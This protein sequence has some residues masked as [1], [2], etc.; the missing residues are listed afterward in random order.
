MGKLF[1]SLEGGAHGDTLE[2]EHE[3][4]F[5][6]CST[7]PFHTPALPSRMV[8]NSMH[9][10][11]RR[12]HYGILR[13]TSGRE[14]AQGYIICGKKNEL[15]VMGRLRFKHFRSWFHNT[16]ISQHCI[17]EDLL[18]PRIPRASYQLIGHESDLT[19]TI[20]EPL[21]LFFRNI[22]DVRKEH[23]V[24][25]HLCGFRTR[26][27]IFFLCRIVMFCQHIFPAYQF[28]SKSKPLSLSEFQTW[29]SQFVR[30]FNLQNLIVGT[31]VTFV[32]SSFSLS[33]L[34]SP[35]K[36]AATAPASKI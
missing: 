27:K 17:I 16:V 33:F 10:S 26:K 15:T 28:L 36:M 3:V 22:N 12:L 1:S 7:T 2:S 8:G 23:V 9:Q 20:V 11:R 31:K 18:S 4:K 34:F 25:N 29:V 5:S 21:L 35:T 19:M 14:T 24:L 6:L 32:L 30:S 13:V